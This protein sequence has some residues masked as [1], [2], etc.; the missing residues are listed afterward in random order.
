MKEVISNIIGKPVE[1][2]V[3][4]RWHARLAPGSHNKP[5]LLRPCSISTL[6]NS[7]HRFHAR[8]YFDSGKAPAWER[9]SELE[10]FLP[11]PQ[12]ARQQFASGPQSFVSESRIAEIRALAPTAFD[13]CKLARLC[14]ELNI[15]YSGRA[16]LATAMLTRAILDHVPPLFGMATFTEV[17]NNYSGTRSFKETM[18]RLEE[19]ARKIADAHLHGQI[20][21]KE[22]LPEPQQVNFAA[23]VDVLLAEI[24]RI[25]T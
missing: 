13:L 23:E 24:V 19:A 1:G 3:V 5:G 22:I 16:L 4:Q 11:S 10:T 21:T 17:A 12:G 15:V 25:L 8:A 18:K 6:N 20:R 9:I 2:A 14:A 7:S